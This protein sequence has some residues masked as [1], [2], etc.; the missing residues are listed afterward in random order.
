MPVEKK[1]GRRSMRR[2][3]GD[4]EMRYLGNPQSIRALIRLDPI[5]IRF[6][7]GALKES[8]RVRTDHC[9]RYRGFIRKLLCN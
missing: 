9:C 2:W 6:R 7:S 5:S 3:R 1:Y 8:A 4:R